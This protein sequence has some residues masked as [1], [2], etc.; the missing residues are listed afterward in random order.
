MQPFVLYTALTSAHLLQCT[1]KQRPEN[2][3][4]ELRQIVPLLL[5]HPKL[6]K[7]ERVKVKGRSRIFEKHLCS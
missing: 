1:E 2:Q 4:V 3:K 7:K 5:M 6:G